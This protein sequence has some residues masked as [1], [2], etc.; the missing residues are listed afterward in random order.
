MDTLIQALINGTALGAQ[1]AM[2]AL[3]FSL[4]FGVLGVINLAHGGFY[5]LGGYFTY[6]LTSGVGLPFVPALILGVLGVALV[7]YLVELVLIEPIVDDHEGT[8]IVS[9]GFF[10][11][12]IAAVTVAY[13]PEAVPIEF[14]VSSVL[15]VGDAYLPVARLIVIAV[16]ALAVLILWMVL[17]RTRHGVALRA[18]AENR[19]V[20]SIQGLRPRV[21]FPVAVALSAGL[22]ALAGGLVLPIFTLEPP[23]A[24]VALMTSFIIVVLGGLGSLL[25][26][27]VA[28][29][30]VGLVEAIGGAYLDGS[31][32]KL[33]LFSGVLLLLLLR[34]SGIAG[35]SVRDA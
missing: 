2:L 8:L 18:L 27:A 25:G 32:T 35:R 23:V 9:L 16:A 30:A 33:L 19:E 5:M 14:P 3:G 4:V 22:A 24:E 6:S 31:T 28:A 11:V 29:L 7:G 13:G 34:P 15:R 10:L 17:F 1:Y 12:V 21:Y 26:A 20:A